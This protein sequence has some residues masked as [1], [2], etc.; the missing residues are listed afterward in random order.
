MYSPVLIEMLAETRLAEVASAAERH[1]TV[2]KPADV[3]CRLTPL[4][5]NETRY[6]LT[7]ATSRAR[8]SFREFVGALRTNR[9]TAV[10]T[11]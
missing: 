6:K 4:G 11:H 1:G 2:H 8:T 9:S 10:E 3:A 7:A 5:Q